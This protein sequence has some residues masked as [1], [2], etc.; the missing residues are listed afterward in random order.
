MKI[1]SDVC[2]LGEVLVL[3]LLLQDVFEVT[4]FLDI[5]CAEPA[6]N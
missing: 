3:L 5:Y 4:V 6:E 2:D 1:T